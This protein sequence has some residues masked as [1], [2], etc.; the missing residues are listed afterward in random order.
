V[1]LRFVI[2]FAAAV[3]AVACNQPA[4]GPRTSNAI[5]THDLVLV[6]DPQDTGFLAAKRLLLDGTYERVGIPS[7]FLFMTSADTNDLKVLENSQP[8]VPAARTFA[9]APNP[10]ETL[11]IPVL[12]RPT[13]LAADEG[14]NKEGSRVTG[15]YVY[16]ARPGGAEISVVSVAKRRQLTGKPF[17]T[18]A[19]VTAISGFMEVDLTAEVL[20]TPMP[21]T[22]S[23][24]IAT[25][26]GEFAAVYSASLP[27]NSPDDLAKLD[28]QRVA[29][30][31]GTPITAM[32]VAAP[33]ATRTVDGAPFC[34]SKP[35]LALSTRVNSGV[36]GESFMIDPRTGQ[37]IDLTFS[38]P[39]RK[40]VSSANNARIY[41][42]LDEQ[43]CGG[44]ACGGIVAVDVSTGTTSTGFP[45]SRDVTGTPMV[46]L[47]TGDGLI[48]GL[49]VG[50]FHL[51]VRGGQNS[52]SIAQRPETMATDGGPAGQ[53]GGNVLQPYQELGAFA[54]SSGVITF[55][56]GFAGS[57]IDYD[58]R[59]SAV[60]AANVNLPGTLADGGLSFT[61]P[62]GG[63]IGTNT[64]F[65]VETAAGDTWRVSTVVTSDEPNS[66][67][68]IDIS[69]GYLQ[70]QSIAFIYEG[71][72]P[73]LV[74]LPTTAA[75]GVRLTTNG[76]E[77]RALVGDVV[78][79]ESGDSTT[80]YE[81]CGRTVIS[82]IGAG[83]I[84]VAEAP[85]A[86]ANRVRFT[87]R[88]SG[89]K[90]IVV[91][92]D[93]EGYMGRWAPGE[94]LTY[95]RPS[96]LISPQVIA[97]RTPLTVNIPLNVPRV[98]GSFTV[99]QIL[100]FMTPFQVSLD[101]SGLGCFTQLPGQMVMGNMVLDRV[102]TFTSAA[103]LSFTW[104]IMGVVPSANSLVEIP[105]EASAFHL[106]VL[107]LE[108][109]IC[110]R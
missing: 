68:T 25:W 2:L 54:S 63:S 20:Q 45:P 4:A 109:A 19:P 22:T 51:D 33:L 87:V 61:G 57:I 77:T 62:D 6:G 103:G 39:I 99:F 67:W 55:F 44:P 24:Y 29:L 66:T 105:L 85:A 28:F 71:Q 88:A 95:N 74:S 110:R 78:R 13:M 101:G 7:R 75:D 93:V 69:D 16:A 56:S 70:S 89:A 41:G 5:G 23:V 97:S 42:V 43:A 90:P 73:G 65:N 96:I 8:E 26:D 59:R 50:S 107:G 30:I 18:P 11:S 14:R 86:C 102:P 53:L 3:L 58:P 40:L 106:G 52:G 100:G 21:P 72:V 1:K 12:D 31:A 76:L 32:L 79:I 94:T 9:P 92:A 15:P 38:G 81:E 80:G 82:T 83:F 98:T 49:T 27:T 48:T 34:A 104:A 84:E 17:S 46:P 37:S 36:G 60:S 47:R 108:A 64:S 10:L 91:A 35:C